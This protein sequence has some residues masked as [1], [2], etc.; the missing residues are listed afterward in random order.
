M[1]LVTVWPSGVNVAAA[2]SLFL[3]FTVPYSRERPDSAAGFGPRLHRDRR[4]VGH[5]RRNHYGELRDQAG[6]TTVVVA[7]PVNDEVLAVGGRDRLCAGG[8]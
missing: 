4:A 7:E 2:G 5:L 8:W 6:A 1:T 3:R